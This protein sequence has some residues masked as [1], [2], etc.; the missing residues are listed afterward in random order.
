MRFAVIGAGGHAKVVIA[1]L[2]A[3]GHTVTGLYDDRKT[4]GE[5]VAGIPVLGAVPAAVES[6]LHTVIAV[7]SNA[8]RR[9][10]ATSL[11][12]VEWGVAIHPQAVMH[13]SVRLGAGTVVFAGTVL[14]PDTIV[15]DHVI[16]NTGA[17]IDHDCRIGDFVHVAPGCRLAGDVT[18]GAGTLMGICSF[19][20]PG[21]RIGSWATVGAGAGVLSS[22][23]DG[24]T[25][26]G[27]PAR[28]RG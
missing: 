6:G 7:G 14:Q 19:A 16:V 22:V 8:A 12:G 1:T 13:P 10:I 18:I 4:I 15:G 26:V 3:A 21:A 11:P 17:S 24:R 28:E 9:R 20:I 2:Q 25:V 27:V 5:S 23:P